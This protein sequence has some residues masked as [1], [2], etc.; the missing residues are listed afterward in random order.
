MAARSA[1]AAAIAADR[2]LNGASPEGYAPYVAAFRLGLKEAGYV[3]SQNVTIEYRWAENQYDRLPALA[4]DLVRRNV[5][6]IAATST[7]AAQAAKRRQHHRAHN[8]SRARNR[9]QVAG[10]L[11]SDVTRRLSRRLSR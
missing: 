7:P 9:G 6:V 1:R 10:T 4:A 2:I 11:E 3:E 5:M 8:P